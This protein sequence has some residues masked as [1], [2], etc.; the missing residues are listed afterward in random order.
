M[1]VPNICRTHSKSCS[2]R[3]PGEV[4]CPQTLNICCAVYS[5]HKVRMCIHGRGKSSDF[6]KGKGG[7]K[8][9]EKRW[10]LSEMA[11]LWLLGCV[12]YC[13][14]W[15][16]VGTRSR[17]FRVSYKMVHSDVALMN[18][19]AGTMAALLVIATIYIQYSCP[20]RACAHGCIST[21]K[22]S[23]WKDHT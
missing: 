18:V 22:I 16:S 13:G 20:L 7:C 15:T 8:R 3:P 12:W 4:F 11:P 21:W 9:L 6:W 5:W 19:T 23:A 10:L 14:L 1:V 17:F 2:C